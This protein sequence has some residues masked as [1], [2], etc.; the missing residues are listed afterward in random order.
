MTF[1]IT[2]PFY[3]NFLLTLI[4]SLISI[5]VKYSSKN[6]IHK[7]FKKEDLAIGFELSIAAIFLLLM[8]T[9]KLFVV[10]LKYERGASE[11]PNG[12]YQKIIAMPFILLGM[13]F[14]LWILST[15]VRKIGWNDEDDLSI[16]F[17][18]ILPNLIGVISLIVAVTFAR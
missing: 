6:D 14:L 3:C 4:T 5:F 11:V 15:I 7:A 18:I 17:G 2:E 12:V 1:L 10:Y 13:V 16:G 9:S 8:E